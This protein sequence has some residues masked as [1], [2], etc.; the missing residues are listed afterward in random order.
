[1][2]N[3][4]SHYSSKLMY[5]LTNALAPLERLSRC[6]DSSTL[7]FILVE[8]RHILYLNQTARTLLQYNDSRTALGEELV[9]AL[10]RH[11]EAARLLWSHAVFSRRHTSAREY[12]LA[13][14]PSLL[15]SASVEREAHIQV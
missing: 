7:G 1:M 11:A 10:D 9:A 13:R 3:E 14:K 4:N 6:L 2:A 12:A 15:A 5:K 8:D